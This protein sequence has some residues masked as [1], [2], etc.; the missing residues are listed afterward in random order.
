MSSSLACVVRCVCL[1][2][3]VLLF[4][5]GV[6]ADLSIV[7]TRFIY[8]QGLAALSIRVGNLGTAPLLLQTW[9]DKGDASV[10]PS[11]LAVPFVL[12]PPLSRL[13]PQQSSVLSLRYSG[14]PLPVDR[15]SVF[16]LNFLE[17]P[18][19]RPLSSNQLSLSYRLRMK[20]LYRPKGLPGRADEAARQLRWSLQKAEQAALSVSNPTPYYVSLARVDVGD[21]RQSMT[22]QGI[23][24]EPFGSA[25]LPLS[26]A[27]V[28][29]GGAA[30]IRYQVVLDSGETLSGSV[31][32][33]L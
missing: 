19:L 18:S 2:A 25:R 29:S 17:V 12:S 14:E 9:L 15:E 3:A 10:D 6:R 5:Q 28:L 20:L 27:P 33:H 22:V 1:L 4:S 31:Q 24:V 26:A 11:R 32:I 23:T 7:G 21:P 16:W 8:P 30:E 13:D